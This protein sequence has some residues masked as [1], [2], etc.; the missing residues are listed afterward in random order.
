M[1]AA[2]RE[3]VC[4]SPKAT[5]DVVMEALKKAGF[6]NASKV[7]V[8]TLRND[9]LATLRAAASIGILTISLD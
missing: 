6:P 2:L 3:I 4:R 8:S 5:V 9:A 1:S 7:T